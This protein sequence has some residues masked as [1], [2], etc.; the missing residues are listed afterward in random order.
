MHAIGNP[1]FDADEGRGAD[2]LPKIKTTL[3]GSRGF[4]SALL[5]SPRKNP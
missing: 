5:F 4:V 3:R 2:P 1:R